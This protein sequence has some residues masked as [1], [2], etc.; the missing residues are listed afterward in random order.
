MNLM[1]LEWIESGLK[2]K[3]YECFKSYCNS[4]GLNLQ[5]CYRLLPLI[6]ILSSMEERGGEG[7]GAAQGEG[8]ARPPPRGR[9]RRTGHARPRS[10][11]APRRERARARGTGA[12]A[13]HRRRRREGE[14]GAMGGETEGGG[15]SPPGKVSGE[16]ER[17]CT[18]G[19]MKKRRN[20]RCNNGGF[21]PGK[22]TL[23]GAEAKS[24]DCRRFGDPID[25]PNA[26]RRSPRRDE[27]SGTLGFGRRCTI[28][29]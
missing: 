28:W 8:G 17:L 9:P 27:R 23:A 24:I 5:N 20:P 13:G 19:K 3:S 15:A 26:L 16:W 22:K 6:F 4:R 7:E 12:A 2:C 18:D 29:E 1:Q 21:S 10:G 14:R 25:E 11:A